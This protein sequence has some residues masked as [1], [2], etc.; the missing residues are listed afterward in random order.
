[1]FSLPNIAGAKCNMP[2]QLVMDRVTNGSFSHTKKKA[3]GVARK[4]QSAVFNCKRLP[5]GI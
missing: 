3:I 5:E 1:M 2:T 4:K